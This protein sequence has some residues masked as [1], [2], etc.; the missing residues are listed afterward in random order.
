M[1][2]GSFARDAQNREVLTVD[3]PQVNHV[4]LDNLAEVAGEGDSRSW[5][6]LPWHFGTYA[7][8]TAKSVQADH[9]L[10]IQGAGGSQHPD[11]LALW[12]V[13]HVHMQPG[14]RQL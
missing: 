8:P 1:V 14:Q 10:P 13:A 6:G 5:R 7:A 4:G 11:E 9:H 2:R 3:D 12:S